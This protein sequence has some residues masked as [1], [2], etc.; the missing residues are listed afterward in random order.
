MLDADTSPRSTDLAWLRE[1]LRAL[2]YEEATVC[3]RLQVASTAMLEPHQYP[4]YLHRWLSEPTPLHTAIRLFLLQQEV[5]A[6]EVWAAFGLDGPARLAAMGL[7]APTVEGVR[8]RV[9]LYPYRGL[10][11][12]TDRSDLCGDGEAA[13][14]ERRPDAVMALNLSTHALAQ[15]T[16]PPHVP[17][18]RTLDLGTGCG[19]HA[20]LA[21]RAG[22]AAVGTDL[23]PRALDFARFNAALNDIENVTFRE[24]D[25]YTPVAGE[26]FDRILVNPAFILSSEPVYLFRDGGERGDAMSR[27]AILEA[28]QHLNEG[29]ICQLVGEF[30]TI[31]EE[32]FEERVAEWTAGRGCDLLLL[33]FN[34]MSGAEYATLYSQEPFGQAYVDYEEAWRTRWESFARIGIAEIAFGCALLRRRTATAACPHW[35]V[36]R[37]APSLDVPLGER[38]A[39]FLE[40]Q[41]RLTDP[42]SATGLLD[43]KPRMADGLLLVEG[44]QFDGAGWQVAES[45]AS[46]PGDPFVTELVLSDAARDLL[47]RCDGA[48]T[49]R[50]ALAAFVEPGGEIADV[51]AAGVE[52]VRDLLE[53]GL[54]VL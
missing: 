39:R 15:V 27:R 20:L 44:R 17:A 5:R 13:P 30:P 14:E 26:R 23:N 42:D 7:V 24:G 21:A 34:T 16:L 3:A 18:P 6:A 4:A 25:L 33:R 40:L 48:R 29:G 10:W 51:E 41:D 54:L 2:D 45:H 22:G 1:R 11:L 32:T 37:P 50:E 9:D 53:R 43:A 36:A 47:L 31:G 28:P 38:L 19:V 49:L 12:A 46:V 52:A 8:P 35:V